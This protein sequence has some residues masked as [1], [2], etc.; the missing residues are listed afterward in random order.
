LTIL[1][2]FL[3]LVGLSVSLEFYSFLARQNHLMIVVE[4]KQMSQILYG[5]EKLDRDVVV[6]GHI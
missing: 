4:M 2:V 5:E 3:A 1:P 6:R